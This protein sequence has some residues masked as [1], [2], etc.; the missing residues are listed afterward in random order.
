MDYVITIT[1]VTDSPLWTKIQT[2]SKS[3]QKDNEVPREPCEILS[4]NFVDISVLINFSCRRP[5]VLVLVNDCDW[6]LSG[7]LNT[8]LEDKDVVVFISTLHGG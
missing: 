7:H 2:S 8:S 1:K 4:L 6:E 5:G 3:T